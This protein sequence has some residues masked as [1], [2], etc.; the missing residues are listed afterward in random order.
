MWHT[1]RMAAFLGDDSQLAHIWLHVSCY[2]QVQSFYWTLQKEA[3]IRIYWLFHEHGTHILLLLFYF[4]ITFYDYPQYFSFPD[5][6]GWVVIVFLQKH[7]TKNSP[8]TRSIMSRE[9]VLS[10]T[11]TYTSRS[12]RKPRTRII[13]IHLR[14][15]PHLY[16]R[17]ISHTPSSWPHSS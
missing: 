3:H 2:G 17:G 13:C 12:S 10:I 9:H 7:P 1:Y 16:H 11:G 6:F 8:Y 15:P 14:I 4:L 5:I